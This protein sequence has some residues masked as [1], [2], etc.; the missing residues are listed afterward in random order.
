MQGQ[1]ENHMER[2]FKDPRTL[3]EKRQGPLGQHIDE[4]AEQLSEQGYSRQCA[5]RQLQLVAELSQWMQQR[6]LAVRDLTVAKADRFLRW[7][8]WP[9]H[10]RQGDAAGLK[11]FFK[12][13]CRKGLVAAPVNHVTQTAIGKLQ[14]DF[15]VY[16]RQERLLAR[17]TVANYLFFTKKF[18]AHRFGTGPINLSDLKVTE[19]VGSVQRL[20]S[21]LSRKRAKVMTSALRSFLR[22]ARYQDFIRSDLAAGVPCVADWSVTSIPKGLPIEHVNRVLASCDRKSAIGRR[23]YA[24]LLLLA[25]LGLRA[26]EVASL[27]LEDIDWEAGRLTVRGKGDRSAQ[28]PLPAD[29]GKAIASYLKDGRQRSTNRSVFLRAR[30]P[31]VRLKDSQ[32]V[33]L[34]VD[35]ALARAGINCRRKGAHQFRHTLATEML[36]HGAS[37]AEIGE[38]LRHRNPQTSAIYAKVDLSSLRKL[39]LPWP[40]GVG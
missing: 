40:G 34:V 15:S 13:L 20:A 1:E 9:R 2:F 8:T 21:W 35:K 7:R 25:R 12:L 30:A 6:D 22:Y 31:A 24:I 18:L 37:L 28:L 23:D 5:C 36:R 39:A 4:F 16:L 29:V 32:S 33:G 10:I 26:G 14:D 11:G 27:T 17:T 38:V 19:V 3:Q